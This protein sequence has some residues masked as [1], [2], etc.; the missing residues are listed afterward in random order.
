MKTRTGFRSIFSA[1]LRQ[2]AFCALILCAGCL[3]HRISPVDAYRLDDQGGVPMLVPIA[4]DGVNSAEFQTAIISLPAGPSQAKT[5]VR[6]DCR[7]EG[8]VFSLKPGSPSD[9]RSWVVRG[10]SV[11]GWDALGR[12][13]DID[14]QW[15]IFTHELARLYDSGCFPPGVPSQSVRSAIAKQIPFVASDVPVFMYSD[16]GERFVNLA[17]DMEIRIQKVMAPGASAKPGSATAVQ[18]QTALF[19]LVPRPN[20]GLWLKRKRVAGAS[21]KSEGEME[22]YL[23]LDQRFAKTPEL[24]LFLQG[25]SENQPQSGALLLGASNATQLDMLTELIRQR[26]PAACLDDPDTACIELPSGSA[27]LF[28]FIWINDRRMSCPFGT[29]LA[30]LLLLVPPQK[31]TEVLESIQVGRRV[32]FDRYAGIQFPRTIEAA[33]ELLLLPGDRLIGKADGGALNK[34]A[35]ILTR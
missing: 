15:R 27:S 4:A 11:A 13:T 12:E 1:F 21:E 20:R 14:A 8:R 7:I 17:P 32:S 2:T 24:R 9:H 16:Q 22:G 19:D 30:S 10:P 35:E 25:I 23:T 3:R 18:L 29:S 33:R 5:A 6:Q 31:Q 28:S 26:G 34:A